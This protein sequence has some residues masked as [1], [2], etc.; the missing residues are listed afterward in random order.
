[1][2]KHFYTTGVAR[3]QRN[4]R[5]LGD[6]EGTLLWPPPLNHV[7]AGGLPIRLWGSRLHRQGPQLT[8]PFPPES[9]QALLPQPR[10][11]SPAKVPINNKT[12]PLLQAHP[13]KPII[14]NGRFKGL[15]PPVS[16]EPSPW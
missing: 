2:H 3:A 12:F 6:F 4:F 11:N 9:L 8:P 16:G 13:H 1:M 10:H 15:P 5:F 7:Y 14:Q